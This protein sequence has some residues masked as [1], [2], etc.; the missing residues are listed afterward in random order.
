[1]RNALLA[2][3]A[4]SPAHGYELKQAFEERFG[5][6]WPPINIGQVYVTLQRLQRDGLVA[7]VEV[8]Q[9]DRPNKTVYE[10]TQAGREELAAWFAA[11]SAV[12]RLRD[13]FVTRVLLAGAT[14]MADP[15]DLINEQ[16]AF[17]LRAIRQLTEAPFE[18][19][20]EV[21]SG[22]LVEGATLHLEADLKWLDR[23]EELIREGSIQ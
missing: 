12:P 9:S 20:R 8:E 13:D 17:Y 7:G 14:G 6:A 1:M 16:R 2:L 11:P 22:L 15:L 5:A 18:A 10:P 19:A 4:I 21:L 23:C 3:L